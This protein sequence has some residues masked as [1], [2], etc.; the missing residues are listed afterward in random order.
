MHASDFIHLKITNTAEHNG[1][2]NLPIHQNEEQCNFFAHQA[3]VTLWMGELYY[4]WQFSEQRRIM[5]MHYTV[6]ELMYNICSPLY[7]DTQTKVR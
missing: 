6:I 2:R 3:P 5:C 7:M 4:S 1:D